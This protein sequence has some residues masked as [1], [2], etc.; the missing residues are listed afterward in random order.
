MV[1]LF[2]VLIYFLF[3]QSLIFLISHV[4]VCAHNDIGFN[5]PIADN[6]VRLIIELESF[7]ASVGGSYYTQGEQQYLYASFKDA[8]YAYDGNNWIETPIAHASALTLATHEGNLYGAFGDG[9]YVYDGT[10]WDINKITPGVASNMASHDGQLYG[11]FADA[12]Y[13]YGGTSWSLFTWPTN[14]L[15][16]Y[17]GYLYAS[18]ADAVYAY[19]GSDWIETPVAHAPA[20]ALVAHEGNLYGAFEDG[21]YVYDGASW[22]VNK[23]TPG[24]ASNMASYDGKLYGSFSDATYAYDGTSWAAF[25]WPTNALATHDY[26]TDFHDEPVCNLTAPSIITGTTSG[27]PNMSHSYTADGSSCAAGHNVQYRFDWDDGSMSSWGH[28]TRSKTWAKPGLYTVKAQS[29]CSV[30][31]S[32]VSSWSSGRD[33]RIRKQYHSYF[34]NDNKSD[35]ALL[36]D[37]GDRTGRI[38][39]LTSTGSS[40]SGSTDGWR[41]FSQY[42]LNSVVHAI[43][44]DFNGNGLSDIALVYDY[45]NSET[46]I[47]VFTSTGSGF[48]YSG[49]E[50]W[51]SRSAGKYNAQKVIHAV[52]GGTANIKLPEQLPPPSSAIEN[53]IKWAEARE[54]QYI[55][56]YNGY[57][58]AFVRDAYW[59]GG[60]INT[61]S[62]HTSATWVYSNYKSIVDN[63]RNTNHVPPRG[64]MVLYRQYGGNNYPHTALSLGNGYVINSNL[65]H[66]KKEH[67][68][69]FTKTGYANPPFTYLGWIDVR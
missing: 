40:F 45:G 6:Q 8:V 41:Q 26:N 66:I 28:A 2:K 19:D 59:Y 49:N 32:N 22:D 69:D 10:I 36:Y 29:R 38:H 42:D 53:A 27:S 43:P 14:A 34:N 46:R 5:F 7:K 21:I 57:C 24:V 20:L 25:T 44:G 51:W 16:S 17:Q 48:N 52:P 13:A 9:V 63:N 39:V 68:L 65:G 67:Y 1:R 58:H 61:D 54:G 15:A 23:I 56:Q 55:Q 62:Y 12:T 50:G 30:N 4:P 11:S 60:G 64:T 3:F 33:V 18:F 47:H 31:T 35:I 37:Y